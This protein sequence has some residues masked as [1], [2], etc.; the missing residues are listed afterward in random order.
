MEKKIAHYPLPGVKVLV[1][2]NR[3]AL[4]KTARSCA[5]EMG[6]DVDSV[7]YVLMNLETA[8]FYKSMTTHADHKIWQDVYHYL[9]INGDVIYVKLSVIDQ[10]LIVSF[11]ER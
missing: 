10:V 8:H 7:K 9:G 6:Y 4:T 11:K 2:E 5:R 3:F 1:A